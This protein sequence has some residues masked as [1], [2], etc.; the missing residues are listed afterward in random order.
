MIVLNKL[1]SHAEAMVNS[2]LYGERNFRRNTLDFFRAAN[3]TAYKNN[4]IQGP[5]MVA[6]Y[7]AI[8]NA[9]K[10]GILMK[11]SD[12]LAGVPTN[13]E[14]V[15]KKIAKL[16][17]RYPEIAEEIKSFSRGLKANYGKSISNRVALAST[18]C[19]KA[20]SIHKHSKLEGLV[21]TMEAWYRKV[22]GGNISE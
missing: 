21:A 7:T 22:I 8:E 2:A 11:I 12:F 9:S 20:H 1:N 15:T 19:V 5:A 4:G 14:I 16:A 13:E 3:Q 18:G 6:Y 17:K 10:K